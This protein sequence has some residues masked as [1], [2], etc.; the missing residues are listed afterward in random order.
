VL[1][2]GTGVVNAIFFGRQAEEVLNM[3]IEKAREI[4]NQTR[5]EC[6]PLRW[7]SEELIGMEIVIIGKTTFNRTTNKMQLIVK[8]ARLAT[9]LET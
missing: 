2:D 5:N 4:V 1:D 8:E 3:P 6:A 9:K 7:I